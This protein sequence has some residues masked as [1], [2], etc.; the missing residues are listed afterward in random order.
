MSKLV[1]PFL[2]IEPTNRC[3][4]SCRLCPVNN[5]MKRE[6]GD[7]KFSQ[8][9]LV[10]NSVRGYIKKINLWNFGEPLLNVDIFKI[11]KYASS[12]GAKTTISTNSTILSK[13]IRDEILSSGLFRLIVC[14]D[15]ADAQ[16]HE[17]YRIGSNFDQIIESIK[18]LC[19]QRRKINHSTPII[20]VQTLVTK[21]T[22]KQVDELIKLCRFLGVDEISFKD[23]SL[24]SW[25]PL[26]EKIRIS[27]EW[28]PE[29]SK[30]TRYY[31]RGGV[32]KIKRRGS[33]CSWS[34]SNGVVLCNGDLTT[35]CYDYDGENVFAN[36]LKKDYLQILESPLMKEIRTKIRKRRFDLCSR[37]QERNLVMPSINLRD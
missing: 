10:F 6:R 1:Y 34:E 13:D 2:K 3:N 5:A 27:S 4:L 20:S 32:L 25:Q 26:S 36:V 18:S 8:F 21:A 23:I 17:S 28:L 33:V 31:W 7:L 12:F 37:C 35:C 22:E 11:V 15:G 9:K 16:T 30:L 14:I 19:N 24:G 29:N